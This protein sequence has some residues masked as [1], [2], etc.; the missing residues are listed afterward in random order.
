VTCIDCGKG[1]HYTKQ[2][3]K[4]DLYEPETADQVSDLIVPID[5]ATGRKRKQ[6]FE[7]KKEKKKARKEKNEELDKDNAYCTKCKQPG[8][9]SM[10]SEVEG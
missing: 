6:N 2:Y 9:K 8:H 3:F 1:S 10:R 5:G 4:C 7:I